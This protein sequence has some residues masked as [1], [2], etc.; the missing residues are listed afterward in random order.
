MKRLLVLFLLLFFLTPGILA[1]GNE[2]GDPSGFSVTPCACD[3]IACWNR[4]TMEVTRNNLICAV[5]AVLQIFGLGN[6]PELPAIV[7]CLAS[8]ELSTT[9]M[10]LKLQACQEQG[11]QPTLS[12]IL[13][14]FAPNGAINGSEPMAACFQALG[15]NI[16]QTTLEQVHQAS[17]ATTLIGCG[18]SIGTGVIAIGSNLNCLYS[19][20]QSTYDS[21]QMLAD[22]CANHDGYVACL[23][24]CTAPSNLRPQIQ[25]R[26]GSQHYQGNAN[27]ALKIKLQEAQGKMLFLAYMNNCFERYC[28]L[29]ATLNS[30]TTFNTNSCGQAGSYN[31]L[32]A[33]FHE[34]A[35]YMPCGSDGQMSCVGSEPKGCFNGAMCSSDHMCHADC[36]QS[37]KPC[38]VISTDPFG[39]CG[40][41]FT[42]GTCSG[43]LRCGGGCE[44]SIGGD[45]AICVPKQCTTALPPAPAPYTSMPTSGQPPASTTS[46]TSSP[47]VGPYNSSFYSTVAPESPSS[48]TYPH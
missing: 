30:G 22:H 13:E 38:C 35:C 18:V 36:G 11:H 32:A 45:G 12:G 31:G 15:G 37:G 10:A 34:M 43:D 28:N 40:N 4:V 21:Q 7:G 26:D 47:Y 33:Q 2:E 46:T 14:C 16:V 3:D 5:G 20:W 8:T 48:D 42:N 24:A 44:A 6:I 29:G 19:D 39:A 1:F 27:G 41:N 25:C 9:E 23:N 17:I